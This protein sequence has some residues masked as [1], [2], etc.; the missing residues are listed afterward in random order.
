MG[1]GI[2]KRFVRPVRR[3]MRRQPIMA[4]LLLLGVVLLG[5]TIA[6][7]QAGQVDAMVVNPAAYKPLLDIIAKGESSGNYNAHY[8]SA[9]N[10]AVRFTEMSVAEVLK[11]QE[12]HVRQGSPSS[13]VGKYQIVRT[14]LDG[15]VKQLD[16]DA[17]TPYDEELQDRLAV[18]LLERRGSVDYVEKE[19]TREQFAANLAQEWAALPKVLGENPHE[20]YYAGDGLNQSRVSIEEVFTALN[21]LEEQAAPTVNPV[22]AARFQ[23]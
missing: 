15:L 22:Q 7:K 19:L 13:A 1:V 20:S 21:A 10:D 12:E 5:V 16:I 17:K 11:W 6:T 2:K 9:A 18:A 8:G 14:T 3:I 4:S 23:P